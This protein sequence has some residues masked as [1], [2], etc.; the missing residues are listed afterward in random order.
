MSLHATPT[1]CCVALLSAQ[2]VGRTWPDIFV[3]VGRV[4]VWN[5]H[6]IFLCDCG[7]GDPMST[8]WLCL[9]ESIGHCEITPEQFVCLLNA[10]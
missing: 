4:D 1:I 9:N 10:K 3:A 8:M 2:A 7:F 6:I 5:L